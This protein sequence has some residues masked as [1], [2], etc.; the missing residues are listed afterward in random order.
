M[1]SLAGFEKLHSS[2]LQLATESL[3]PHWHARRAPTRRIS[4]LGFSDGRLRPRQRRRQRKQDASDQLA[5]NRYMLLGYSNH[6]GAGVLHLDLARHQADQRAGDQHQAADPDP[7]D[8][9]EH[10]A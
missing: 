1:R 4:T 3:Q 7:R 6:F 2:M 10:I 5:L 8:Q 9:R